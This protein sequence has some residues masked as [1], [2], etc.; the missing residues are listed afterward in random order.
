MKKIFFA[1]FI[2]TL[3]GCAKKEWT[4]DSIVNKCLKDFNKRNEKEKLFNGMQIPLLCDCVA[5]KMLAKYKSASESDK[6]EA[7]AMEI[8][9]T[10]AM[11]VI[12]K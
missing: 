12:N 3:A 1:I 7:G 11:E 9:R 5:D 4:K 8:G 6:D 2:L 10:C